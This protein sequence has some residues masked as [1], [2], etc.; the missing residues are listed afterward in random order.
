MNVVVKITLIASIILLGYN[1]SE[2]LSSYKTV[3]EKSQEFRKLV[4]E[5][6]AKEFELRRSNFLMS[7]IL[8]SVFVALTFFSGL[9]VWISIVLAS[10]FALTL[11]CSDSMLIQVLRTESLPKKFYVLS[12][13]DSLVNALLGLGVALVLV[14]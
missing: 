5:N 2:F 14:L 12:K 4:F 9:A 11:Y 3:C 7:F 13:V 8:S 10:K 6:S 1:F